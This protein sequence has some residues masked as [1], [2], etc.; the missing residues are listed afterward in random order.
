MMS[1]FGKPLSRRLARLKPYKA[2]RKARYF[3]E[4]LTWKRIGNEESRRMAQ[5][6]C[7][8]GNH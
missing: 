2:H 3:H 1:Q 4:T 7:T 6:A 5:Y 8:G